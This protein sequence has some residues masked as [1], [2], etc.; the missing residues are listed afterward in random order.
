M[1]F[2]TR[3]TDFTGLFGIKPELKSVRTVVTDF[4]YFGTELQ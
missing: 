4:H 1:P 2:W 3:K